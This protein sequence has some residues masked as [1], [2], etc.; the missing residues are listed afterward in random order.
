MTNLLL[1]RMVKNMSTKKKGGLEN[2]GHLQTI[3]YLNRNNSRKSIV[4]I[5]KKWNRKHKFIYNRGLPITGKS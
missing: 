4:N 2:E 3:L 1:K 5:Y